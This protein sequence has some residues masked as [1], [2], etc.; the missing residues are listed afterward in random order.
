[1]SNRHDKYLS[2]VDLVKNQVERQRL[3]EQE[4]SA[5]KRK[6]LQ[7]Q[8]KLLYERQQL[9]ASAEL[10]A[11]V[12]ASNASGGDESSAE[13]DALAFITAASITDPTQQSAIEQL[14][15]DLHGYGIWTK[16]KAIYPFVGG[17][18]S[19]HKWN[20][21]DPRDLDAAFRLVFNG[22]ITHNS[23]GITGNGINGY[24]DTKFNTFVNTTPSNIHLSVYSR[25]V[26]LNNGYEI[27][28]TV[29][30]NGA[31]LRIKSAIN[32]NTIFAAN[33]SYFPFAT[34]LNV[35][36]T[37]G[38]FLANKTNL[39]NQELFRNGISI[40]QNATT[41]DT[42]ANHDVYIGA[43]NNTGTVQAGSFSTRNLAFSSIGDTLTT[44][45]AA[46]YYTAVQTFQTTLSRQV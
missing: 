11:R 28:C 36:D 15:T 9:I 45:E 16:M 30:T 20:L 46:N 2:R 37:A 21:K 17:T 4:Y 31:L 14:V 12:A 42:A 41:S 19:T 27:G 32:N 13:D 3:K 34:F 23:N 18:A 1:M 5:A 35:A 33:N 10:A 24:A 39:G 6:K 40:R 43:W 44:T 7:Q 22:G 8:N 29:G 25:T 38:L 26:G